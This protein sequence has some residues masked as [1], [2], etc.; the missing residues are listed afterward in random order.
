MVPFDHVTPSLLLLC[1]VPRTASRS[2]KGSAVQLITLNT[3]TDERQRKEEKKKA[4]KLL[5]AHMRLQTR[6]LFVVTAGVLLLGGVALDA[7]Y[8]ANTSIAKR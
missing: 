3:V 8:A 6:G 7:L 1:F 5:K 2:K 4:F